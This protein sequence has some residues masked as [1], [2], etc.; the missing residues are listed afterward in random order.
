MSFLSSG[1]H[2]HVFWSLE[3]WRDLPSRTKEVQRTGFPNTSCLHAL[4]SWC[5]FSVCRPEIEC[6]ETIQPEGVFIFIT[7]EFC[8]IHRFS[9][10][11][12]TSNKT[13]LN[14]SS[15][16]CNGEYG[17]GNISQG[18]HGQTAGLISESKFLVCH[19]LSY[20]L[21]DSLSLRQTWV[22]NLLDATVLQIWSSLCERH[23]S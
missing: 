23:P 7:G 22:F 13:V 2:K 17:S 8:Q 3:V 10:L 14:W 11:S 4:W 21:S 18:L 6:K 16:K 5:V 12:S 1:W 15:W 19:S 9:A 20:S